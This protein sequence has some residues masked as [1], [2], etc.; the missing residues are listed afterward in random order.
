MKTNFL[1]EDILS[2]TF[3][4][5]ALERLEEFKETTIVKE[6]ITISQLE[7]L[8]ILRLIGEGFIAIRHR[9]CNRYK[10]GLECTE[11][12]KRPICKG[13]PIPQILDQIRKLKERS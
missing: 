2:I 12:Q 10:G 3:T 5:T 8:E 7:E 13:C 11:Y 6:G 9:E 4:K 1:H